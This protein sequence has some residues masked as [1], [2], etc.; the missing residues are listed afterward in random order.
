MKIKAIAGITLLSV[1]ASGCLGLYRY[2]STGTVTA[3]SGNPSQAVIYWHANEG[4]LW[5]KKGKE[6]LA[7]GVG[8]RVCRGIPKEFVPRS[9][10]Q[11][12]LLI[13][14]E[15]GD[16]QTMNIDSSGDVVELSPPQMLR[17]GQGNCGQVEVSGRQATIEMF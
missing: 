9:A 8:L 3:T 17:D 1:S 4:G 12:E 11:T 5:G 16:R 6:V 7:S 13:R 2:E 15:A 10:E 14:S